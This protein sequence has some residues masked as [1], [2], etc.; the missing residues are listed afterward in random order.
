MSVPKFD[1]ERLVAAR[2]AAK[3]RREEIA[4][5]LG[6]TYKTVYRFETG[7]REPSLT[8]AARLAEM[9]RIDLRELV[10]AS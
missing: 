2:R 9:C 4:A 8:Q 6:I 5:D 7:R 1:H 10:A 3:V